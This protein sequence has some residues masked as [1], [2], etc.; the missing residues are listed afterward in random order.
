MCEQVPTT[1][2]P[3]GHLQYQDRI[4]WGPCPPEQIIRRGKY[5]YTHQLATMTCI[6]LPGSQLIQSRYADMKF[7]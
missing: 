2:L 5:I 7:G 4:E 1:L 3:T 6:E